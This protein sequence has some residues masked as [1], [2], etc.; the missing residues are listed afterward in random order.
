MNTLYRNNL[1]KTGDDLQQVPS[2]LQ[3]SDQCGPH[4]RLELHTGTQNPLRSVKAAKVPYWLNKTLRSIS[5]AM[6]IQKQCWGP[7]GFDVVEEHV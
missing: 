4:P 1:K 5:Y 7:F 3:A 6:V 2:S